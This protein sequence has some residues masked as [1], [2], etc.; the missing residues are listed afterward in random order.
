[1]NRNR[2]FYLS[3]M[4]LMGVLCVPI[5][6]RAETTNNKDSIL[7]SNRTPL[8]TSLVRVSIGANALNTHMYE[9]EVQLA[10]ELYIKR[11]VGLGLQ[12]G[13]AHSLKHSG[14]SQN[15]REY[16][17]FLMYDNLDI[18]FVY[19]PLYKKHSLS[20][21]I[22]Y[23][24]GF[25]SSSQFRSENGRYLNCLDHGAIGRVQYDYRWNNNVMLGVYAQYTNYLRNHDTPD[26]LTVGIVLGVYL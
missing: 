12:G 13:Y 22:G 10:L 21:G 26:R 16:S 4:I 1:M 20:L 6:L 18:Y 8:Y 25:F 23:S 17:D 11:I 7:L 15:S 5:E 3:F 14:G 24:M 9:S 19:R 2:I